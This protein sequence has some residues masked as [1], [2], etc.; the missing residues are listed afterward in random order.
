[1]PVAL[2]DRIRVGVLGLEAQHRHET[3]LVL[4]TP[5][6]DGFPRYRVTSIPGLHA[7]PEGDDVRDPRFGMLGEKVR[8]SL[9]RGKT[10]TYEGEIQALSLPSL[11]QAAD[12]LRYAFGDR[13]AE[14]T[15]FVDPHPENL[16]G[17]PMYYRARPT[18]LEVDEEQTFR[19]SRVP[20]P[21]CRPF[22]LTMR[23][24]DPRFYEVELN[25]VAADINDGQA[26]VSLTHLG[27]APAD[28]TIF[29]AG[30]TGDD[31]NVTG[32]DDRI[33]NVFDFPVQETDSA[34][35]DFAERRITSGGNDWTG[36]MNALSDWWNDGEVGIPP[37]STHDITLRSTSGR[38][39]VEWRHTF[40]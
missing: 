24:G 7:L 5:R 11:R 20:S 36:R 2:E 34:I 31:W 37:R 15:M 25:T 32:H 27:S 39:T 40:Y 3:G 8:P 14:S 17:R 18:A 6:E 19:E 30:P 21:W 22:V 23:L 29:V 10:V 1:M 38:L 28:P 4:N 9:P 26:S 13:R 35:L 12:D 33:I 16:L